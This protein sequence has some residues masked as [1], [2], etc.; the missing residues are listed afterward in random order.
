MKSIYFT[1]LE[2]PAFCFH[3]SAFAGSKRKIAEICK[4]RKIWF[5]SNYVMFVT[6]LRMLF[7]HSSS[8]QKEAIRAFLIFRFRE[9]PAPPPTASQLIVFFRFLRQS[10]INSIWFSAFSPAFVSRDIEPTVFEIR[11]QYSFRHNTHITWLYNERVN[12]LTEIRFSKY[13]LIRFL[14]SFPTTASRTRVCSLPLDDFI[15]WV[16]LQFCHRKSDYGE[17][18]T[19]WRR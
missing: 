18:V 2:L 15:V 5:L 1:R 6:A 10:I 11:W 7:A 9:I 12:V 4:F 14:R 8:G 19:Y 17:R 16:L 13:E 3:I